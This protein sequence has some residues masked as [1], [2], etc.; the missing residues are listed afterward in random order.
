MKIK[1][2]F[3]AGLASAAAAFSTSAADVFSVNAVGFVNVAVPAGQ[4]K[5]ISNPLK[6]GDNTLTSILPG[7]PV[8]TKVYKFNYGTQSF[9]IY[10]MRLGASPAPNFWSGLNVSTATFE[11]GE[12]FFVQNPSVSD[13]TLTFVGEVEQGA[14]IPK[15]VNTGFSLIASKVPQSGRLEADL[16]FV[17][18]N[19]DKAYFFR[20]GG[21]LIATRRDNV[22]GWT[23]LSSVVD[24]VSKQPIVD[25]AEGFFFEN[26]HA[27]TTWV[28]NFSANN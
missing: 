28:R 23:G 20:N 1:T 4:F 19:T 15:D 2:V 9:V 13:I 14:S 8:G 3:L 18:Q 11:T 17:A 16:G 26:K 27:L 24:P 12:G 25:I 5:I 6:Q 10:T 22:T 7:A 21:Y